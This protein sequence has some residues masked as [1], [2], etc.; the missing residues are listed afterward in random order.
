MKFK[1][2]DFLLHQ[3]A[4]Y[5][6]KVRPCCSFS[7]E[8]NNLFSERYEGDL[9]G[10]RKYLSIREAYIELFKKGEKPP[11]YD[12]CTLYSEIISENDSFKLNNLVISNRAYCSF[13]CIYCEPS[14]GDDKKRKEIIN[15]KKVY[16]IKPILLELRN[17][18]LI[19]KGCRFLICGGECSEYP[20][21][22]LAWLLYYALSNDCSIL[23]LSSGVNYSKEIESVLKIKNSVLK[24]SVDSGTRAVFNK[25]KRVEKYDRV[26]KNIKKY[27]NV[28]NKYKANYTRVELKYIIIPGINDTI[29]EVDAF[30]KKCRQVKCRYVRIDV[31]H[32]WISENKYNVKLHDSVS[33]II[34]YFFDK[35]YN[36][37]DIKIDF[38]GVE[39]DWLWDFVKNK[40]QIGQIGD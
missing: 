33:E 19:E 16:D 23:M 21:S 4:F 39:K 29:S 30:I 27:I 25:I 2:C 17:E 18:N 22:E 3:I 15:S 35:L 1:C 12:G 37:T 5:N 28:T 34:N 9:E 24:I 20:K 31:E 36:D 8:R 26:W 11:C 14:T 40:Y 7:I 38:E 6:D 13:S 10:I 32:S